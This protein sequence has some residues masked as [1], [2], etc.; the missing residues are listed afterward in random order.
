MTA[1]ATGNAAPHSPPISRVRPLFATLVAVTAG[2]ASAPF[3]PFVPSIALLTAGGLCFLAALCAPRR[4]VLAY[5]LVPFFLFGVMRARLASAPVGDDVSRLASGGPS[6]WV[7]GVVA[8]PVETGARQTQSFTLAADSL[9]NYQTTRPATGLLRVSAYAVATPSKSAPLR[10][11]DSVRVRGRVE[12]PPPATNPGGFDYRAYL[13]RQG[14][15]SVMVARHRGDVARTSDAAAPRAGVTR[16]ALG[17]RD[18]TETEAYRRLPPDDAALLCGVLL[19]IRGRIPAEVE[20]AFRATGTVHI[21]STSGFHLALL[22]GALLFLSRRLP[23]HRAIRV[24]ASVAC[25]AAIWAYALAAGNGPAVARAALM[26][27]VVLAAPLVRRV[28]HPLHSL[29]FAALILVSVSPLIVYDPGAQLSLGAVTALLLWTPPLEALFFPWEP[30]MNRRAKAARWVCAAVA[31]SLVA[32]AATAPLAL[33]HFNQISFIAPLANLIIAPLSEASL[34]LGMITVPLS[35]ASPQ[36]ATAPLWFPLGGCLR[37]LRLSAL[38]FAA[39]PGASTSAASPPAWG[40]ALYYLAFFAAS[41]PV[42]HYAL[43]K[44]FWIPPP[45]LDCAGDNRLSSAASVAPA[46][47][48]ALQP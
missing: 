30:G 44:I 21:L 19:S 17:L 13:A 3:C 15:F 2:V 48:T 1:A 36:W 29:T 43:R 11:G 4:F 10:Y 46:V 31:I 47:S 12:S 24:A 40:V 18:L 14:V 32:H 34:A 23:A 9:D 25:L 28:A 41:V 33:Y 45:L 8:S 38:V 6:V 26:V 22:A 35:Q 5:L 39:A 42:R 20:D 27:S 37:L 16:T 7:G